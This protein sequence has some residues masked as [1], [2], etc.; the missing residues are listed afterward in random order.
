M[1]P[2]QGAAWYMPDRARAPPEQ[3]I[4]RA[5]C[6]DGVAVK[7]KLWIGVRAPTDCDRLAGAS[8]C[9]RAIC[10]ANTTYTTQRREMARILFT[11]YNSYATLRW[12]RG[13][14]VP[15]CCLSDPCG[16]A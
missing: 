3:N 13:F 15:V 11:N 2:A 7:T 12:N 9:L 5:G 10:G 4:Q 16:P 14:S 6:R 1:A 8:G